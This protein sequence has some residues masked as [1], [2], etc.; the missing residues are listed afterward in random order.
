MYTHLYTGLALNLYTSIV[1]TYTTL[2]KIY[3]HDY[4]NEYFIV[5]FTKIQL[6]LHLYQIYL[7]SRWTSFIVD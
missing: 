5:I 3:A 2:Y 7:T 6:L 1:L 4:C